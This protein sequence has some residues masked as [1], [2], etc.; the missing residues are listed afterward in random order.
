M[1]TIVAGAALVLAFYTA[2]GLA[3]G[4]LAGWIAAILYIASLPV[5]ADINFLLTERRH[6]AI[7]RARTYLR[8]RARPRLQ[9]RLQADL[10]RL[11]EEAV[12]IEALVLRDGARQA[13]V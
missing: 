10:I 4:L 7:Q 12:E 13:A 11:R 5:A 6:R 1:R 3:V 8:F 9:A 2:Q